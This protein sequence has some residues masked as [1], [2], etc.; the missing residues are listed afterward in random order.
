MELNSKIFFSIEDNKVYCLD[1]V[2][3]YNGKYMAIE[4]RNH[5]QLTGYTLYKRSI[6]I[7]VAASALFV[8]V[9]HEA[10]VLYWNFFL[11]FGQ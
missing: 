9:V 10:S 4:W 1:V 6:K 7:N 11:F 2:F 8:R 3:L 5:V